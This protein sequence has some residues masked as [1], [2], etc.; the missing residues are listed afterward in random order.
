MPRGAKPAQGWGMNCRRSA[1]TGVG[2]S[3]EYGGD[4]G[5]WSWARFAGGDERQRFLQGAKA[6]LHFGVT[7]FE[8][9]QFGVLAGNFL[10]LV[11]HGLDQDG[12]D[13]GVSD[14]VKTVG[15][16]GHGLRDDTF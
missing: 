13:F 2:Y 6:G 11:F 8:L 3:W 12:D 15:V 7:L 14:G 5:A 16:L 4:S 1:G 10:L 9:L